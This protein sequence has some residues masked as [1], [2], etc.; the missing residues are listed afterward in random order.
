MIGLIA[1]ATVIGFMGCSDTNGQK[2]RGATKEKPVEVSAVPLNPADPTQTTVGSLEFRGAL[3]LTFR[4]AGLSGLSGLWVSPDGSR[5]VG[6]ED[7]GWIDANLSYDESGSL[8]GFTLSDRRPLLDSNGEAFSDPRDQDAEALDFDGTKYLVG[9]EEHDRILAYPSLRSP[10]QAI[11]LPQAFLSDIFPGA[12]VSSVAGLSSDSVVT[13]AE[14][15]PKAREESGATAGWLLGPRSGP[16]WL[17][18]QNGW[19]PVSVSPLPNG[20]LLL[21]EIFFEIEKPIDQ[22]RLSRIDRK[23]IAVGATLHPVELAV[24]EPPITT[25]RFEGA[26]ANSGPDGKPRIYVSSDV[27]EGVLLY[28]FQCKRKDCS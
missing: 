6:V 15:S 21:L 3:S 25:V 9:F 28:M 14:Y 13:F 27:G 18:Y 7:G 10:S 16:I 17:R 12:G 20:D 8:T 19:V 24:L 26:S 11:E 5:L 4:E 23:E 22:T 2:Q 1:V